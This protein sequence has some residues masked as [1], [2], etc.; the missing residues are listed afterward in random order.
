MRDARCP[1][2]Q[3]ATEWHH[4]LPVADGGT[5]APANLIPLCHDCHLTIHHP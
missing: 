2:G 4:R 5:D 1:C 3:P